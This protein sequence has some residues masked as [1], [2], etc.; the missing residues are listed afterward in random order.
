[1]VSHQLAEITMDDGSFRPFLD[2]RHLK[3]GFAFFVLLQKLS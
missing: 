3:D 2:K 1:M